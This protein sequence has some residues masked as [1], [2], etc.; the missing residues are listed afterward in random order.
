[1]VTLSV[2]PKMLN[3]SALTP[4]CPSTCLTTTSLASTFINGAN[5][6]ARTA[7]NASTVNAFFVNTAYVGA[8]RDAA[9]TWP[10]S[11]LY[12]RL[13]AAMSD[14]HLSDDEEGELLGL[15]A[16]AVGANTTEQG[17]A[18]GSITFEAK[19]K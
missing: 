9:D 2:V 8:V 18:S 4:D 16:S 10:A 3:S 11:V 19:V 14:G 12:P 5:E 17:H 13:A 1:M 15:L 7:F 6:T